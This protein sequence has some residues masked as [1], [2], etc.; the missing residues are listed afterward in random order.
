VSTSE[1]RF[2]AAELF[3]KTNV[4]VHERSDGTLLVHTDPVS[5][6][7]PRSIA[8]LLAEQAERFGDKTFLAARGAD[9]EWQ[10]ISYAQTRAAADRIA[11]WFADFAPAP[12]C[13][14]LIV[15]GNSLAHGLLIFGAA[16]AGVPICPVSAQ[17]A[18]SSTG[19]YGR[20]EHVISVLR[21]T[22][23]FAEQVGPIAAAL[24]QVLPDG[25]TLICTD[26]QNWPGAV[27]WS[28]VVEHAPVDDPDA[29]IAAIEP[30]TP[31]R[32]MLT[33]GSTGL[34]KIVVQTNKMWCSLFSGANAV[35]AE[36]SGWAVQTLDWMPWSHVAGVSVL[37]GALVNGGSFYLDEGR[38]TPELFGATLRNLADVQ[39]RFFANVPFAFGLLCDALEADPQLQAR[40]F[41]HLQLCL[42]GG[43]GLPQPIYDR[44]QVMAEQTIGERVMFT[45]GYGSTETTAGVM[46]V[47]WPTTKVGVGLPLPGIELKLVPL[48]D[49]RYEVRFRA[50]C[51][52]AGYLNNPEATAQAFDDEGFYR[53][54]DAIAFTEPGVPELGFVFAGRL[55]E[56]FKLLSGTFVP[57][58]RLRAEVVA[59][60]SP[61]VV[62][63][64]VCG[65]GRNEVG[66]LL[67]INPAGIAATLGITAPVEQLAVDA[68]VL[69]WI[70]T[71]LAAYNSS[72]AGSSTRVAR[73]ALLTEPPNVDA[74][75]VSEK[76]SINQSIGLRRRHLD[77]DAL[78]AGGPAVR[79]L[80]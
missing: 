5:E 41:E 3:P 35:L 6:T 19:H 17:Y 70:Q 8:A 64:L 74:G 30:E 15:T 60:T 33:S 78:Y 14:V 12:D 69:D 4:D 67:W 20:L 7:I 55:A 49:Q 62:E 54:G 51:V 34:P 2:R 56:E 13:R 46:A 24:R 1:P 31:L 52:M 63:G 65:E 11:G 37:T 53:S 71:R 43:A 77:V 48:D 59:A 32:Y 25:V 76:A 22:V 39:P 40:F 23:V 10:Q 44:F 66:L 9:G 42:F 58:G 61:V 72:G 29:A 75:E 45:T 50:D 57:G 68:G 18:A 38:P 79:V 73:F 80:E 26:P 27:A 16:A 47:S 28:D 36:V 21:P